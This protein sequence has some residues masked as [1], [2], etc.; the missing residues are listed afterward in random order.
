MR[1]SSTLAG[2]VPTASASGSA[3]AGAEAMKNATSGRMRVALAV[4]AKVSPG[5]CGPPARQ[6]A[7]DRRPRLGRKASNVQIGCEFGPFLD[8]AETLLRPVPHQL[9]DGKA[10]RLGLAVDDADLEQRA[11]GGVHRGVL[12]L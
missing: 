6:P 1:T 12:E 9:V 10:G 8:E 3:A 4:I 11:P 2:I 7:V 5:Q